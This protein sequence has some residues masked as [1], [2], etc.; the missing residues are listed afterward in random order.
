[1]AIPYFLKWKFYCRTLLLISQYESTKSS[2]VMYSDLN[3]AFSLILSC[4]KGEIEISRDS[5]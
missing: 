4:M 5:T 2:E 1:M 3:R